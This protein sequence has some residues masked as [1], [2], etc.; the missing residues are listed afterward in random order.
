MVM[1]GPRHIQNLALIGFMGTGKSS[2][3]R[4]VAS[5]LHFKFVDTDDLIEARASRRI[6]E[7][8]AQAG[9]SAFR[10]IEAEVVE[11]LKHAQQTVTATGGGLV[12]NEAHLESLKRHALVVCLWASPQ[13]IWDRVHNQSHRPL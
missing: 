7:I 9:E 8:F 1:T 6:S 12:A 13:A 11:E 3:G 10:S 4:F 2:V 5:Q